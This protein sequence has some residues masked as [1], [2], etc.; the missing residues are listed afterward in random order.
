MDANTW[1]RFPF[2]GGSAQL[3]TSVVLSSPFFSLFFGLFLLFVFCA[4]FPIPPLLSVDVVSATPSHP[5]YSPWSVL[6]RKDTNDPVG[7]SVK[8]PDAS[9]LKHQASSLKSR[10][11]KDHLPLALVGSNKLQESQDFPASSFG[12]LTDRN[13]SSGS[14]QQSPPFASVRRSLNCIGRSLPTSRAAAPSKANSHHNQNV[15][16]S[17]PVPYRKR[18]LAAALLGGFAKGQKGDGEPDRDTK[19]V[20]TSGE[21]EEETAL[22]SA[23]NRTSPSINPSQDADTLRLTKAFDVRSV[24]GPL[25]DTHWDVDTAGAPSSEPERGR[26]VRKEPL[27]GVNPFIPSF[28]YTLAGFE[29]RNSKVLPSSVVAEAEEKVLSFLSRDAESRR[30]DG[31]KGEQ[32]MLRSREENAALIQSF[33]ALIHEW[34][35]LNGY[36]FARLRLPPEFI[37]K[38]RPRELSNS[39]DATMSDSEHSFIV[40]FTC[41]EPLNADPPLQITFLTRPT[42]EELHLQAEKKGTE[43]PQSDASSSGPSSSS[44][45][46]EAGSPQAM[47]EVQRA[48]QSDSDGESKEKEDSEGRPVHYYDRRC[49]WK[50]TQGNLK[51]QA[52]AKHLSLEAGKPFKWDDTKWRKVA[53]GSDLFEE[54]Q[55]TARALPGKKG[56]QVD[57]VAVEKPIRRCRPGFSVSAVSLREIEGKL[58]MEHRNLDGCGA[59]GRLSVS[60]SPHIDPAGSITR[61]RSSSLTADLVFN[62]LSVAA[63]EES[64]R[65]SAYAASEFLPPPKMSSV[66]ARLLSRNARSSSDAVIPLPQRP[67]CGTVGT[68]SDAGPT[69]EADEPFTPDRAVS[70]PHAGEGQPPPPFSKPLHNGLRVRGE[71]EYDESPPMLLQAGH[72]RVGL[73]TSLEKAVGSDTRIWG[74]AKVERRKGLYLHLHEPTVL[75]EAEA[76]HAEEKGRNDPFPPATESTAEHLFPTEAGTHLEDGVSKRSSDKKPDGTEI[77]RVTDRSTR[78]LAKVPGLLFRRSAA[79]ASLTVLAAEDVQENLQADSQKERRLGSSIWSSILSPAATSAASTSFLSD[80]TVGHDIATVEGGVRFVVYRPKKREGISFF[81]SS[82]NNLSRNHQDSTFLIAASA[83]TGV[84]VPYTASVAATAFSSQSSSHVSP[85][86]SSCSSPDRGKG[87]RVRSFFETLLRKILPQVDTKQNEAAPATSGSAYER[88]GF[89]FYP[90]ASSASGAPAKKVRS[91]LFSEETLKTCRAARDRLGQVISRC[92]DSSAEWTKEAIGAAKTRA[93]AV[94]P[95]ASYFLSPQSPSVFQSAPPLPFCG[96]SAS[97]ASRSLPFVSFFSSDF[98]SSLSYCH[99]PSPPSRAAKYLPAWCRRLFSCFHISHASLHTRATC[100]FLLS[101]RLLLPVLAAVIKH[102]DS[103]PPSSQGSQGSSPPGRPAKGVEAL[104]TFFKNAPSSFHRSLRKYISGTRSAVRIADSLYSDALER[105]RAPVP[106]SCYPPSSQ[107]AELTATPVVQHPVLGESPSTGRSQREGQG[108]A[109]SCLPDSGDARTSSVPAQTSERYPRADLRTSCRTSDDFSS[110]SRMESPADK[111]WLAACCPQWIQ[112]GSTRFPPWEML[113]VSSALATKRDRQGGTL[114]GYVAEAL[115][116][117][118]GV[119]G[120]GVELRIP[121]IFKQTLFPGAPRIPIRVAEVSFFA[122]HTVGFSPLVSFSSSSLHERRMISPS[123]PAALNSSETAAGTDQTPV[124]QG[125]ALLGAIRRSRGPSESTSSFSGGCEDRQF[126][127][128]AER[129]RERVSSTAFSLSR[130]IRHFAEMTQDITGWGVQRFPAIGIA[131]RLQSL[132]LTFAKPV[133]LESGRLRLFPGRFHVGFLEE[134]NEP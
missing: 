121:I 19:S 122:D 54:A 25:P 120:G 43:E 94:L 60:L 78:S 107:S 103:S 76:H 18:P 30:K 50:K 109:T 116:L 16:D 63:N 126:R 131:V 4:V 77:S 92:R 113:K 73:C 115:G 5:S 27:P 100:D 72:V 49:R 48:N 123:G 47:A 119:L 14:S 37:R 53:G 44:R 91:R 2:R 125:G 110:D 97:F 101:P 46:N 102:D 34:Y 3:H 133:L 38:T 45:M 6:S 8:H 99:T 111:R 86:A 52:L 11:S 127:S 10:R 71:R 96:F 105:T 13:P 68:S 114:R 26:R 134:D 31:E 128:V 82:G 41:E 7:L 17:L 42:K 20:K 75:V 98:P 118:E 61:P 1:K 129:V 56:I 95:F 90:L 64:L 51:P 88:S 57:V 93:L 12:L 87:K 117:Y 58:K 74:R 84:Y 35:A 29:V 104:S 33:I 28:H 79:N 59:R 21:R 40:S 15:S 130:S 70:E 132:T 62:S 69:I 89:L 112:Q 36:V 9:F 85:P 106:S 124:S 22:G 39:S 67:V 66:Q 81:T 80:P 24:E 65:V 108:R 23:D 83:R 55:A 32:R